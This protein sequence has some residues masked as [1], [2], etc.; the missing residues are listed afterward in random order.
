M[1]KVVSI[2]QLAQISK[3]LRASGKRIVSTNGCFDL[4]HLGHVRSLAKAKSL[5]DVLIVGVNSD[6]SVRR[7]KG[8][9]RPINSARAR[10]EVVAALSCV[11]YVSIFS[12]DD[13]VAFVKAAHPFVHAKGSHYAEE[14]MCEA[15]V[16]RS[17][18]GCVAR[19]PIVPGYSTTS[20]VRKLSS[21]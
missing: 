20:I 14:Q 11:D 2:K 16:V 1:G 13:P 7:L 12:Q 8:P 10:A 17:L 9:G 21:R 6:A 3:R 18:G 15:P 4:L 5:G 19:L